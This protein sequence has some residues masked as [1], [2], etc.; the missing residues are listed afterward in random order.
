MVP[1]RGLILDRNGVVLAHNFAAYTLEITP[2]QVHDLDRTIN[3]LPSWS[4]S[5]RRTASASRNCWKRGTNFAS[6]PIRTRL[7]DEEVARFAVNRYRFP[8]VEINARLFRHYPNGEVASHVVGY[9]GRINDGDVER[10]KQEGVDANY[11]GSDY[12]GKVGLEAR[13]ERELHGTTGFEQVE[14][15]AGGR[16]V[17]T[18]S[19]SRAG[20]GQQPRA[21]ARH[22]AA[23][24]RRA[25]VRRPPRLAGGDRARHRRRARAGVASPDSTR[26]CSSTASIRRTGMR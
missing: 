26:I 2:T 11:S 25:G 21:D 9:I 16:A 8:G 10:S 5:R 15:D 3:E 22:A 24:R 17:R 13:Y 4:R 18:L 23:A 19:R 6:L 14:I 1:N 7:N 12:I 20:V